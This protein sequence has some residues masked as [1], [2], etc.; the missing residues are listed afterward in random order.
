MINFHR[1]SE[2]LEA[3]NSEIKDDRILDIKPTADNDHLLRLIA[4]NRHELE[5]RKEDESMRS[6]RMKAIKELQ[7]ELTKRGVG[8]IEEEIRKLFRR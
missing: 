4:F 2:I 6:R 3:N 1:F 7:E 5:N 8:D